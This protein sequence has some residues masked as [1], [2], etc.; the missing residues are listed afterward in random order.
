MIGTPKNFVHTGHLGIGSLHGGAHPP[1]ADKDIAGPY[2]RRLRP[3]RL[4]LVMSQVGA[5]LDD[6][7]FRLPNRGPQHAA[8][9]N[10]GMAY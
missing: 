2:E 5:E 9:A 10:V 6:G 3:E 1:S 7:M 4:R 8:T